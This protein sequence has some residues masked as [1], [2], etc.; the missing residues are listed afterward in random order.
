[1]HLSKI[2]TRTRVASVLLAGA[3]TLSMVLLGAASPSSAATV[4]TTNSE[5]VV[6]AADD[7][8]VAAGATVTGYAGAFG[9]AVEIPETITIGGTSYDVTTIGP[10]SFGAAVSAVTF[11]NTLTTI[12][13]YAFSAFGGGLSSVTIPDSVTSIG[14]GAF[15]SNYNLKTVVIGAGITEIPTDA[16]GNDPITSLT[17][18]GDVTSIGT[19]AFSAIQVD[20]FVVPAS[21]TSIGNGVLADY[22]GEAGPA[23]VV[24]LGPAPSTIDEYS[25]GTAEVQPTVTYL[26]R[27]GASQVDGGYTA[28]TWFGYPTR[29]IAIVDFVTEAD[30]TSQPSQQVVVGGTAT[31]PAAPARPGFTFSG[32]FSSST[33]G[34]KFDFGTAVRADMTLYAQWA[35]VAPVTATATNPTIPSSSTPGSLAATGVEVDTV[36]AAIAGLLV[37]S[38]VLA[39]V[40]PSLQLGA[41]TNQFTRRSFS[42][43]RGKSRY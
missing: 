20:T 3:G 31:E 14:T 22:F 37:V 43:P 26:W 35:A 4:T 13:D 1:M 10:H 34:T 7:N 40:F 17:I 8:N 9:A 12:G 2:T 19:N 28:P 38:G 29:A 39:L 18:G 6:F 36:S 41:I 24:F 33:G 25:L 42:A 27:Y 32:W 23:N 21:V 5:G 11:P 16:F 30:A 15:Y